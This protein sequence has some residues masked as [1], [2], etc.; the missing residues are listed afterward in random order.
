MDAEFILVS[1]N[2][3]NYEATR[4]SWEIAIFPKGIQN[5]VLCSFKLN[6]PNYIKNAVLMLIYSNYKI[7]KVQHLNLN[8]IYKIINN[9]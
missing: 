3:K 8:D 4:I 1:I 5:T 9:R 7:I 2:T 6:K